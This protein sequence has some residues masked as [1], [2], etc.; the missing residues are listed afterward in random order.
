MSRV[1][2]IVLNYK[3]AQ[4]ATRMI[5]S[6][7]KST[8]TNIEIFAVE[9][10]SG[11]DS[12]K[13]LAQAVGEKNVITLSPNQ[14]YAGGMNA[15]LKRALA[16]DAEFFWLLTKDLTVEPDTLEKLVHL[17]PKLEN[18]G[19]LGCLTDLNGTEK[20]YFF[21]SKIDG[22]GRT[23]HGT[24]GRSISEIPELKDE[25]GATDYVNGS[26][27]FTHRKVLDKVGLIAE[28]YFLYFE[29][30]DW[31]LRATRAGFKN[32]VSY[33]ARV[34]HHREVG[35]FNRTAEYYCRRNAYLFKKKNGFATPFTKLA[36]LIALRKATLKCWLK[37]DK[38]L[39]EVLRAV[40][41]DV[42]SEKSGL[43]PWR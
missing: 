1:A 33:R 40:T 27:V 25:Y 39:M 24:K 23:R 6:L 9:N 12:A 43:G 5:E 3:D 18:P 36:E 2:C 38:R 35:G 11:D 17:W 29:D 13:I 20:V 7:R 32:Y 10:G 4:A 19:M 21:R 34:H 37:G 8:Y 15:G 31:G 26:C 22:K 30:T 41:A 42:R 14:G 28:D 16:T